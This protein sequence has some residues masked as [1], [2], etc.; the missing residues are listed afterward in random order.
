MKRLCVISSPSG[1]HL[2][3]LRRANEALGGPFAISSITF[4][5]LADEVSADDRPFPADIVLTRAMPAGSL[6][7]VVFRMDVLQ[8]LAARNIRIVNSPKSIEASVDKYLSLSLMSAAGLPVP[9]TCVSQ[10]LAQAMVDFESF[11]GPVVVKPLF[12]SLGNGIELIRNRREAEGCFERLV[13]RQA[14]IYQQEYIEHAGWDLRLLVIGET[15]IGMKRTNPDHWVTNVYQGGIGEA[16]ACSDP[17]VALAV[18]SLNAVDAELAGV[19]LIYPLDGSGPK[20]LEVNAAPGWR[21]THRVCD[22][23]VA[24]EILKWLMQLT[25]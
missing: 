8:R 12:G 1:W 11:A 9:R 19:D 2:L 6:E 7:Q 13:Q 25:A 23:D 4:D 3:D 21:A 17:E 15:V 10:T 24:S 14:V 18:A 20:V 16:H 22:I 5:Q